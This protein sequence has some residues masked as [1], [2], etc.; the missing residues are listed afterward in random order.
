MPDMILR[1]KSLHELLWDSDTSRFTR[2]WQKALITTIRL[3]Y[4]LA[5]DISGG[6]SLRA[7]SLV[8][9]TLLSLVPLLAVSFSV[10][11]AFG[12]HHNIG[13]ILQEFLS[14]LGPGAENLTQTIIGFVEGINAGILG[15]AGIALLFYT[16]MNLIMKVEETFD[17]IWHVRSKQSWLQRFSEYFSVLLIGP[18]LIFAALGLTASMM[19]STVVHKIIAIEPFGTL[20]YLLGLLVPYILVITV[21]TFVY[22]LLPNT[23]VRFRPAIIG[24]TVAGL[25]WK[26][27]GWLFSVFIATSTQYHAIYSGFT[28]VILFMLWVYFSWMVFIIGAR[29]SFY[30]QQP[31]YISVQTDYPALSSVMKER[32]VLSVMYWIAVSF[33]R[34]EDAPGIDTLSRITGI[35]SNI[36][37]DIVSLLKAGHYIAETAASPATYIPAQDIAGI[38]LSELVMSVRSTGSDGQ[39]AGRL[40]AEPDEVSRLLNQLD[41][42]SA[43]V[44]DQSLLQLIEKNTA[45]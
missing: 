11:K 19:S 40:H 41:R 4:L 22:R 30:I 34:A 2:P 31:A 18:V 3:L 5:G 7:M 9:I 36:V 13:P 10:L 25:L 33:H 20:Y 42:A 15:S 35:P 27:T 21:F 12:V 38:S 43:S 16:V 44:L 37:E 23:A 28:I 8:Y 39:L 45:P 14:A 32:L 17:F 6:L 24:A 26:L 1:G 29:I